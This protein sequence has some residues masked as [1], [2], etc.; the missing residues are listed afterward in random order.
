MPDFGGEFHFGGGERV[1]VR[2]LNVDGEV[3][4]FIGGVWGAFEAAN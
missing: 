3:S 1:V 2:K 4:I